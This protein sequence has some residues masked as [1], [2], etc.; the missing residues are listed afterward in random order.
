[1]NLLSEKKFI[2]FC[3]TSIVLVVIFTVR[4][5]SRSKQTFAGAV[6]VLHNILTVLGESDRW[7]FSDQN[8]IIFDRV[9]VCTSIR[10]EDLR[11]K[12]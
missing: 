8:A 9:R 7:I 11:K 4:I 10:T 1:M 6:Y 3:F 2:L 5:T 12:G